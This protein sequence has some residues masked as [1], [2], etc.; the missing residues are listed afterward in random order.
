MTVREGHTEICLSKFEGKACALN[1]HC[2]HQGGP[3]GE[4]SIE[5]GID[6]G[7]S[8]SVVFDNLSRS[9]PENAVICVDVGNNAYPLGRYFECR[10]QSFLMSG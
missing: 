1:N 5:N 3:L 2:P 10:K 8:S 9:A 7:I 4:G 6:V